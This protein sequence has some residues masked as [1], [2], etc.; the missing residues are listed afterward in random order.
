MNNHSHQS[1]MVLLVSLVLL[2]ILTIVAISAVSLS[3]SQERMAANSQQQNVAFQAAE[4][5]LQYWI[6]LYQNSSVSV[7]ESRT[8]E[9]A[10]A[11]TV[12]R[13]QV[14]AVAKVCT[15]V[16]SS[17]NV[18]EGSGTPQMICYDI[19]SQAKACAD[20][21]CDIAADDGQARAMHMQGYR[22]RINL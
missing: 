11:N 4:S 10:G 7:A 8:L 15:D 14:G 22:A 2:L 13:Y 17:L 16:A 6:E 20:A 3:S 18:G 1:G 12:P 5:G 21:A 19:T 9:N